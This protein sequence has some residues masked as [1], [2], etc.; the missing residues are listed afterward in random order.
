MKRIFLAASLWISPVIA[1][2]GMRFEAEILLEMDD[3]AF[4]GFSSIEVS[5]D[6]GSLIATSD[7]GNWLQAQI[8]RENGRM[9]G[10]EA[11]VLSPILDST[12]VPLSGFNTDAEGLAIAPDGSLYVSFESNHRVM[13]QESLDAIPGF[14]PKHPDFPKLQNNSGLEALAVD[15][16]G[17]LIAI[18]ERSGGL[19]RP[20]TVYR[21]IDGRWNTDWSIPREGEYLVTGADVFEGWLYVLE[22]DL[23]GL[24]GFTSRIRRFEMASGLQTAQTL[25]TTRAGRFDNLEGIAI[26]K[27]PGNELRAIMISD[28]NFRFFQ[29]S[30]LVE[31]SLHP[32]PQPSD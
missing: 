7:R 14:V 12:G 8:R 29:R 16:N 20:F 10:L 23:E 9:L 15:E 3:E 21:Y 17:M 27:T 18:P 22:R 11:K 26:W 32:W 24:F 30:E 4:G 28:D 31:F 6:G 25:L 5:A 19:D 1:E 2:E 13:V